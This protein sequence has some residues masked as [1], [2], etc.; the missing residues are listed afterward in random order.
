MEVEQK[1]SGKKI[2]GLEM[3]ALLFF[4]VCI[5]ALQPMMLAFMP[6]VFA[7]SV[8]WVGLIPIVGQALVAAAAFAGVGFSFIADLFL[9]L[10][11]LIFISGWLWLKGAPFA[12]RM[13][14]AGIAEF[15]P[16]LNYLPSLTVGTWLSIRAANGKSSGNLLMAAASFLPVGRLAT[17][18]LGARGAGAAGGAAAGARARVAQ[19]QRAQGGYSFEEGSLSADNDNEEEQEEDEEEPPAPRVGMDI[20]EPRYTDRGPDETRLAA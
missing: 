18:A 8:G 3:A 4:A 1:E 14:M 9:S 11:G 17:L 19:T 15:V 7:A 20:R 13:A 12:R 5:D 2:G 10:L 16:M 6:M